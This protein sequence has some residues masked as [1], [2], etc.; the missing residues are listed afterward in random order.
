LFYLLTLYC[1]LRS[2]GSSNGIWWKAAAA[3]SCAL[4]MGC[5]GVM[6]TAP[7]LVLLYDR[8][9]LSKSWAEVGR[10]RW[11]FYA[12]LAA[13]WT[14]YP[15]LLSNAPAEWKDSAGFGY[16][17]VT[18][19]EYAMT[20]PAVILHYLRLAFWPDPL[21]LD[22]GWR[23]AQSIGEA[24]PGII[25]VGCLL[26][27]TIWAWRRNPPLGFLGAWFFIILIPTSS[28][29]PIA[30]LAVEH[31]MYLSLAAVAAV[32]VIGVVVLGRRQFKTAPKMLGWVAGVLA[33]V[34]LAGLTIR[35]NSDYAS[36]LSIQADT[37]SKSPH[38]PRAQYDLGVALEHAGNFSDAIVH[39][40]L[41]LQ[42]NPDYVDA[43]TNLGHLL[44][45]G[46][47]PGDAISPLRHAL[48]IK[49][50]LA[51]AHNNL[52]HALVQQGKVQEAVSEWEEAIRLKPDFAD[53][54][55]NLGIV[56][57]QEG[58]FPEA[59]AQWKEAIQLDPDL[60]DA[61]NNL[62]YELSQQG[63]TREAI[64]RYEQALRIKPGYYQ[65]QINFARLLA[66]APAAQGGD[67]A[68]AVTLAEAS[69]A[70][71]REA[72]CL[73][74]LAIAYAAAGR[75]GDAVAA[76]QNALELARSGGQADFAREIQARLDQYRQGKTIR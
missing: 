34:T 22:Y 17:G 9:F 18:P 45:I 26:A 64:T 37:A 13:T 35:R 29:I 33:V 63:Q 74:T 43:L 69:C 49:P 27:A 8:A 57:A 55:N 72:G 28:F 73:D 41:A 5:K 76:D 50:G 61:Y 6:A 40:D 52:G 46:G 11:G 42:E 20:Q 12:L 30:D 48:R 60:V 44:S 39:Y 59:I 16:L 51:E 7:I 38:N 36:D 19:L 71:Q 67:P 32:G 4:G 75:F 31:R 65:A 24:L 53:P 62:A 54:H 1:A 10:R 58:K 21:C 25:I 15:L 66:T 70:S 68:R 14:L 2:D 23:P 47:R 56:R 3:A